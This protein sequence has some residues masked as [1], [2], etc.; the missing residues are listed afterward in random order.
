MQLTLAHRLVGD[1]TVVT[2]R[3]RLTDGAETLAL[4][5]A[6]EDLLPRTRHVVLHLGDIDY[7]DSAGLG[8]LARYLSRAQRSY[9]SLSICAV[10]SRIDEVLRITKLKAVFLPYAN[11]TD[12]ITH[13][14]RGDTGLEAPDR[15][16]VLC[17]D[18]STDVSAYLRELL[19]AAGYRVLTAQNLPDA[20]ILLVATTPAVVVMSAQLRA[21]RGTRTAEE[22]HRVAASR[23]VIELPP[24]F[25]GHEA[26][27]AADA[28]LRA[29]RAAP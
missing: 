28:V 20:L 10:S 16:T 8:L 11:E 26:G 4:Q 12:A 21:A 5:R 14:H 23:T 9:G 25:S 2:C 13:A 24:G 6:L 15:P 17:V 7:I 19:R 27:E 1:A 18:A 22:F 29:V 3:G